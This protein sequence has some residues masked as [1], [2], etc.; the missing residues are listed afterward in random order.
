MTRTTAA[1]TTVATSGEK[2]VGHTAAAGPS[3]RSSRAAYQGE[4]LLTRNHS[5][6]ADSWATGLNNNIL[7]LGCS[8]GGKT[9]HHVKPTL[10]QCQGS[11]VVLDGKGRLW[12]E[13][14]PFMALNGYM[15]DRLDFTGIG[16]DSVGYDPLAQVR[17]RHGAPVQA[18]IISIARAICPVDQHGSDPFWGL[19]AAN[20]LASFIAYVFEALPEREWNFSSVTRVFEQAC[21]GREC[22]MFDQLADDDPTS[23]AVSLYRRAKATKAASKMHASIMGIIAANLLPLS[24]DAAVRCFRN[25]NQVDLASFGSQRRVLFVTMDDLDDSLAPLTSLF[26]TQLIR[27]LCDAADA[28][29]AGR[30]DVPVRLVLDDFANLNLPGIDDVLAVIR[31]REISCTLVCQTVSQLEARY[32]VAAANSIV[33]NCD[34]QLVMAFQD[35]RTA[36]YF[37]TRADRPAPVLLETPMDKWWLFERGQAGV[38]DD[39]YRLEDHPAYDRLRLTRGFEMAGGIREVEAAAGSNPSLCE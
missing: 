22:T 25:P 36:S 16:D 11:Y 3:D 5:A 26:V 18:D 24:F 19:A 6:N 13:M 32:G 31:S 20:Y 12:D 38:L 33:G 8:G 39:A 23:Y 17:W 7:V 9:R 15:V 4:L 34:R 29:P 37:G 30:L 27:R 2:C 28:T 14:A 1:K 21:D 35:E 10:M